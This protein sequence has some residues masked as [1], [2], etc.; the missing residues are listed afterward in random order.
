MLHPSMTGARALAMAALMACAAA[1]AAPPETPPQRALG[2]RS[3]EEVLTALGGA[4]AQPADWMEVRVPAI[5]EGAGEVPVRVSARGRRV[6][7]LAIVAT[8]NPR[9][10]VAWTRFGPQALPELVTRIRL[11]RSG[12]VVVVAGT[13]GGVYA[14]RRYVKVLKTTG[15]GGGL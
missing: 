12:D 15:C 3:A 13:P 14:V 1:W 2:E 5:P 10:L 9:P 6:E 7:W 11:A 8:P 4:E